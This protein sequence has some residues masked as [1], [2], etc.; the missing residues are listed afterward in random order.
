MT[1]AQL[2][3]LLSVPAGAAALAGWVLWLNRGV[4]TL[5]ASEPADR[6]NVRVDVR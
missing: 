2:L 3:L 5:R 4:A 1:T 6:A